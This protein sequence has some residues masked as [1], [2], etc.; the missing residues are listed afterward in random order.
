MLN[1]VIKNVLNQ[2]NK[3]IEDFRYLCWYGGKPYFTDNITLDNG[4]LLGIQENYRIYTLL[5]P[6]E[7]SNLVKLY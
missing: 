6:N 4:K 1:K 2:Y 5:E 3:S 7:V